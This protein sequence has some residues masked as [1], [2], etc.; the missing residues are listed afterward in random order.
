MIGELIKILRTKQGMGV[1]ELSNKLG[2]NRI[3]LFRIEREQ[4]QPSEKTAIKAF[5]LF[6]LSEEEI[7]QI[8]V[9]ESLLKLGHLSRIAK[10]K[11]TTLFMERLNKKDPHGKILYG[12]FKKILK[13]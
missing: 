4:R 8:F 11:E 3:S 10:K 5:K 12:Y 6:E 7:Y 2:I 13:K 9:F 1:M